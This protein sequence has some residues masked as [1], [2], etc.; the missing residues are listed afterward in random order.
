[1]ARTFM[2]M[3]SD[4]MGQVASISPRKAWQRLQQDTEVLLIDVR[5][6]A[7]RRASGMPAGSIAISAGM[8]P[9]RADRELPEAWRDQ[10]VQDRSR[11]IITICDLGPLSAISTHTLKEMGFTDVAF[12]D[13]GVQ[14]W[15]EAG[16]PTEDANDG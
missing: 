9:I 13:G 15:K 5:D 4:A 12:V 14:A 8:L 16:L 11:P 2:Q 6:L 10:R 3:A 1:M 7:D